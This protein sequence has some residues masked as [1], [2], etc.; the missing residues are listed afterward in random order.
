MAFS[1][2]YIAA[3]NLKTVLCISGRK[4]KKYKGG[5]VP[6]SKMFVTQ[7]DVLKSIRRTRT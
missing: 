4:L 6:G 3:Q 7:L 5:V 2:R 1:G